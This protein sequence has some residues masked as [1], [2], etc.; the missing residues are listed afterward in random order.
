LKKS[1]QT[2]GMKCSWSFS[3]VRRICLPFTSVRA[4]V[5]TECGKREKAKGRTVS[6]RELDGLFSRE[7]IRNV[8]YS[9]RVVSYSTCRFNILPNKKF[10]GDAPRKEALSNFVEKS[11]WVL[12]HL[13]G[14]NCLLE[15]LRRCSNRLAETSH[16]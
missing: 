4:A 7:D 13:L 8:K 12:T 6:Y 15:W 10:R 2:Q 5:V 16:N 11:K 14:R 9:Q 3:P 1:A